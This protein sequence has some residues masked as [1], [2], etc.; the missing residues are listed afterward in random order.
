MTEASANDQ[1]QQLRDDIDGVN[2]QL[3]DVLAQRFALTRKVGRLKQ[4]HGLAPT[5]AARED[6]IIARY[7]AQ[8]VASSLD[9]DLVEHIFRSVIAVAAAEHRALGRKV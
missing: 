6:A 2:A 5:D 4:E 9:P 3:V 8:A 1:L 7:R